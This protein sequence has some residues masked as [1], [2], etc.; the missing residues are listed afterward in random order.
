M[1]SG[2]WDYERGNQLLPLQAPACLHGG[3][4][5]SLSQ[6]WGALKGGATEGGEGQLLDIFLLIAPDRDQLPSQSTPLTCRHRRGI[7]TTATDLES[8]CDCQ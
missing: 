2:P 8:A 4:G 7:T 6:Y 5:L 3:A 1:S